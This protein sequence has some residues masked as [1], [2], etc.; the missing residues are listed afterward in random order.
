MLSS[1]PTSA[2]FC[3]EV[4]ARRSDAHEALDVLPSALNAEGPTSCSGT[5]MPFPK[6]ER[7]FCD[8]P[9]LKDD[10]SC[11]GCGCS[12]DEY[13]EDRPPVD[14]ASAHP[15]SEMLREPLDL[16]DEE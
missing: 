8:H 7:R 9:G 11:E 1:A 10:G 2:Q 5:S 15:L 3:A 6:I 13:T 12:Y 16:L 14:P 4:P